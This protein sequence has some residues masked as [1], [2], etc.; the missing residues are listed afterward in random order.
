VKKK[1]IGEEEGK[2]EIRDLSSL[3][4]NAQK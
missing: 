1:K 3:G 4:V 2:I